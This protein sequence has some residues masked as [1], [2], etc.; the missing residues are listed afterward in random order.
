M[1]DH[2]EELVFG[3][4]LA[5]V[6]DSEDLHYTGFIAILLSYVFEVLSVVANCQSKFQIFLALIDSARETTNLSFG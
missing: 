5:N 2:D 4:G 1:R 3:E 6:A